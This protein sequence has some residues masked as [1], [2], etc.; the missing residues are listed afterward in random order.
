LNL[1]VGQ[2]LDLKLATHHRVALAILPVTGGAIHVPNG[3][4]IT[5]P[6]GPVQRAPQQEGHGSYFYKRSNFHF[7]SGFTKKAASCFVN[8]NAGKAARLPR[9][10]DLIFRSF[11]IYLAQLH[12]CCS[13]EANVKRAT[14]RLLFTTPKLIKD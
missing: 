11:A 12:H 14:L 4:D 13:L 10:D 5:G 8:P 3:R 9:R 2:I 7:H 6:G 1:G